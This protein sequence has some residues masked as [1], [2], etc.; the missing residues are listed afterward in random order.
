MEKNKLLSSVYKMLN[1]NREKAEARI[2]KRKRKEKIKTILTYLIYGLVIIA[3]IGV[4]FILPIGLNKLLFDNSHIEKWV[5]DNINNGWVSYIA[6]Y[7]SAIIG[8]VISGGLTF[9]GVVLTIKHAEKLNN[10]RQQDEYISTIPDRLVFINDLFFYLGDIFNKYIPETRDLEKVTIIN[11]MYYD[12]RDK[13]LSQSA[14]V[15]FET[16]DLIQKI[17]AEIYDFKSDAI[18]SES[19]EIFEYHEDKVLYPEFLI[20]FREMLKHTLLELE[21]IRKNLEIIIINH[22]KDKAKK[23]V[24][25]SK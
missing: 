22:A 17:Y 16:Y 12:L 13:Y 6:T 25:K 3:L 4:L 19:R 24:S 1:D 21:I 23:D 7:I 5:Q 14:K 10:K 11:K 18:Y 9:I 15:N 20:E 8:G 2:R